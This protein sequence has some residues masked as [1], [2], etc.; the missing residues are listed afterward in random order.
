MN[1]CLIRVESD[2]NQLATD[3]DLKEM[4]LWKIIPQD[5]RERLQVYFPF[6]NWLGKKTSTLK[7][8]GEAYPSSDQHVKGKLLCECMFVMSRDHFED[9]FVIK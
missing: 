1:I 3:W 2:S 9:R 7:S 4:V 6:N 8:K 5:H